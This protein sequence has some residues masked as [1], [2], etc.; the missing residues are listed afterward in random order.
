MEL[1]LAQLGSMCFYGGMGS[2]SRVY[3]QVFRGLQMLMLSNLKSGQTCYMYV[4]GPSAISCC[5]GV[6]ILTIMSE[7]GFAAEYG[8]SKFI[9]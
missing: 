9:K 2:F 1:R 3:Q 7:I 8:G 4:I 6:Q 5:V